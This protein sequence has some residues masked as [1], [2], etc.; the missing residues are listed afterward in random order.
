MASCS[1]KNCLMFAHIL[2]MGH[3]RYIFLFPNLKVSVLILHGQN[4][5]QASRS[6]KRLL[7]KSGFSVGEYKIPMQHEEAL[8]GSADLDRKNVK[9]DELN[10]LA[11]EDLILSIYADSCFGMAASGL[12]QNSESLEFHES[13]AN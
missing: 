6:V 2:P 8:E 7:I 13:I 10:K 9:L 1:D 11:C 12:I 5:L 4:F 3:K